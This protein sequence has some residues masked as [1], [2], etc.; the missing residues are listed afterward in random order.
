[1]EIQH[2]GSESPIV[3]KL[4][5]ISSDGCYVE[6]SELLPTTTRLILTFLAN[7]GGLLI[8]GTVV[9]TNPGSG[10]GIKFR[11]ANADDRERIRNILEVV[12]REVSAANS[13]MRYL[14]RVQQ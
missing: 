5:N 7:H 4:A 1:V 8:G 13:V 3:G 11:D 9:R 12:E 6:T 10:I 2:A 14:A